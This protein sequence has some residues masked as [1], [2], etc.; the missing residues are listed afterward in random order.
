M[1][2]IFTFCP[3][4]FRVIHSSYLFSVKKRFSLFLIVCIWGDN[5]HNTDFFT[6]FIN[7]ITS[8]LLRLHEVPFYKRFH[9]K[10]WRIDSSNLCPFPRLSR[11]RNSIFGLEETIQDCKK[12]EERIKAD[13]LE[14]FSLIIFYL[15][16]PFGPLSP[17][18]TFFV[19]VN[20]FR[21]IVYIYFSVQKKE[22]V[23]IVPVMLSNKIFLPH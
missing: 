18:I 13:I 10:H 8:S 16:H 11:S 4:E 12:Q 14:K 9:R 21:N 22:K 23:L 20:Q 17:F 2:R 3:S 1:A 15:Y 5:S 19:T 6:F 7:A